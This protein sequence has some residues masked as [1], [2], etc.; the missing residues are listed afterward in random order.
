MKQ[1]T[2]KKHAHISTMILGIGIVLI[3]IGRMTVRNYAMNLWIGIG[4][5][6]MVVCF[7]YH[8]MFVRCPYCGYSLAGYRPLPEECPKCHRPFVE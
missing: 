2:P 3:L 5:F 6:V 4:L 8:F 1:N 7:I